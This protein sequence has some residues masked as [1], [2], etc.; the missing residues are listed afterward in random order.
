[1]K[2][3]TGTLPTDEERWGFEVK[4]DGVRA[5]AYVDDGRATFESRN[6]LDL[7]PRYPEL[8]GLG[9]ALAERRA[10]LDGEIVA[11]DH[12]GRPSF[13]QLQSRLNIGSPLAGAPLGAGAAPDDS[14][15][16][17]AF[18]RTAIACTVSPLSS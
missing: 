10:V 13:Q 1:M 11:F 18:L 17:S 12:E 4:W 5:M 9:E 8:A 2:A 16:F 3:R 15:T 7:T 6:L 14:R